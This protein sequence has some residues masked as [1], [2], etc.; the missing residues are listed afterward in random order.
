MASFTAASPVFRSVA[1]CSLSAQL[2][3]ASRGRAQHPSRSMRLQP[4]EE[5]LNQIKEPLKT[6]PRRLVMMLRRMSDARGSVLGVWRRRAANV[7]P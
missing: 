3:P 5:G 7:R 6:P 4:M 1:C 2:S